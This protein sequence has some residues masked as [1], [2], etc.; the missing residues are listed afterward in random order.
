MEEQNKIKGTVD[1]RNIESCVDD[2]DLH[3]VSGGFDNSLVV[4]MQCHSCFK[5]FRLQIGMKTSSLWK[6]V[7]II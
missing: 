3:I 1:Q 7:S 4:I 5:K 2:E 6:G